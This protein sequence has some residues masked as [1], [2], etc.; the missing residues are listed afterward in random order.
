VA[1]L[2]QLFSSRDADRPALAQAVAGVKQRL[3]EQM[4]EI[5]RFAVGTA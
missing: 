3:A 2:Q 1:R 5:A 4:D